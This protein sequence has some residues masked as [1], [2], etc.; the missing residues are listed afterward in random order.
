MS[1]ARRIVRVFI[2]STFRDLH[3]ER[4]HLVKVVFPELRERLDPYRID[5]VDI[6][7][8]WGITEAQAEDGRVLS[9]C[10]E[11]IDACRPFFVG[12]LGQRYG[13][14]PDDL[15]EDAVQRYG[16]V[17]RETGKSITELE[18][19]HGVLNDPEMRGRAFFYFRDPGALETVSEDRRSVY[20]DHDPVLQ[21]RLRQLKERIVASGLP[22]V[23]D[24]PARWDPDAFDRPTRSRGRLGGL[25]VFGETVL[26]DLWEAIRVEQDLPEVPPR[27]ATTSPLQREHAYHERFMDGRLEG[28]T[29]RDDLHQALL[30]YVDGD[31]TRPLLLTGAS[32]SGKSS[33]LAR[34][35]REL[36]AEIR[37]GTRGDL[38]LVPHFTGASPRS[39]GL[40]GLLTRVLD[41]LAL[42]Y[43][44]EYD[45]AAELR[46]LIETFREALEQVPEGRRLLLVID[47]V[48]QFEER[49]GA[50]RLAWLPAT[51]PPNVRVVLSTIHSPA[52][53]SEAAR[54]ATRRDYRLLEVEPLSDEERRA[55]AR[56]VPSIAAKTLDESQLELLLSNPA[57]DNPLF[58]RVALEELRGF[59]SF[60]ALGE[61][62][63]EFP[64]PAEKRDPVEEIFLQVIQRV[65][66]DFDAVLV[67][68]VLRLLASARRGLSEPELRRLIEWLDAA[69][70]LFPVLRQLRPYLMRRGELIAFFHDALGRAALARYLAAEAEREAAHRRLAD[71]FDAQP[72]FL[73]DAAEPRTPNLRRVDELPWQLLRSGGVERLAERLQQ[74]TFVEAKA[75]AGLVD[76]LAEDY[77]AAIA[78]LEETD[79]HR[80]V[81]KVLSRALD[82]EIGFLLRHPECLFQVLWNR[83][84]W[85]DAPESARHFEVPVHAPASYVPPWERTGSKVSALLERLRHE[86]EH[87]PEAAP[88][89]R[90]IVPPADLFSVPKTVLRG[91]GKGVSDLIWSLKG[92]RLAVGSWDGT[93]RVW[94]RPHFGEPIELRGHADIVKQLAWSPDGTRLASASWDGTVRIWML[95]G[96]SELLV[97]HHEGDVRQLAWSS[98]GEFVASSALVLQGEGVPASG[99]VRIWAADQLRELLVLDHDS[100]VVDHLAWSPDGR[101]LAYV[102]GYSTVWVWTAGEPEPRGPLPALR[103]GVV[104]SL[105]WSPGGACLAASSNDGKVRICRADGEGKSLVLHDES[106]TG[107]H[108][109]A[110]VAW[111]PDGQR[112]AGAYHDGIVRIWL[113]RPHADCLELSGHSEEVVHVAWSPDGK[114][115]ASASR[116]YT[117]IVWT[118]DGSQVPLVLQGH[119]SN[120]ERVAWSPDGEYVA[121]AAGESVHLWKPRSP[122]E[123][124]GRRGHGQ[125]VQQF[126]W[127]PTGDHIAS[128]SFDGI[129]QVQRVDE[130]YQALVLSGHPPDARTNLYTTVEHLVW[131]PDG[132][133][134]AS[135]GSG[136]LQLWCVERPYTA[137]L[138]DAPG[139]LFPD[140][141]TYL[142]WSQGG[143]HLAIAERAGSVHIYPGDGNGEPRELLGDGSSIEHVAWSLDGK[144]LAGASLGGSVLVW[145]AEGRGKPLV[146]R[147]HRDEV[148]H[149]AWSPN[150]HRLA[151]ASNDGTVRFWS[152]DEGTGFVVPCGG[153]VVNRVAW[154]PHGDRLAGAC[155]DGTVRVWRAHDGDADRELLVLRGQEEVLPRVA[156]SPSGQRLAC[157]ASDGTVRVWDSASGKILRTMSESW[158]G[159][160]DA[161]L[162]DS[163]PPF[164]CRRTASGSC[165]VRGEDGMPVTHFEAWGS[166]HP[167]GQPIWAAP[168][169]S[170]VLLF[171][172]EGVEA[173]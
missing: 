26:D 135:A 30:A 20:E 99:R 83:G 152:P 62:I 124:L 25:E 114:H 128:A 138:L 95:D 164:L 81:L 51:L 67:R 8:R 107:L 127:S 150:G 121:T 5:L 100:A 137:A 148:G 147:G 154:S 103:G 79:P 158:D 122:G 6:D 87:R 41:T 49:D 171:K 116:D 55:I 115:L 132:R 54:V 162:A 130:T 46:D 108:W 33:I 68:E 85:Y 80:Y 4:D 37:V 168:S 12:L 74:L 172:L 42:T 92:E 53:T 169:G 9:L 157:A 86:R 134:L 63:R 31:E 82:Y 111:S 17:Q 94:Q 142:A 110:H 129:V 139:A 19:L 76:D 119:E 167:R 160:L 16:W 133:R 58:L 89:V 14:V 156:W 165:I 21:E 39:T 136:V 69:D 91:H 24:Y 155:S 118:A 34:L 109:V 101:Q 56:A 77:R 84:W 97:L 145:S 90:R 44:L 10:L 40:R 143:D 32:G 93:I 163:P 57:T 18:I 120:V 173:S 65:A 75:E 153:A 38:L 140:P 159:S 22:V 15:P 29:G 60:E 170:S 96:E 43:E 88:W 73:D 7:L 106:Y 112:L 48:N 66:E 47:A 105:T 11:Q 35:A 27:E 98:S 104:Q 52:G 45:T 50:E 70:D 2:S 61:R 78:G 102:S 59:P 161:V 36:Q 1:D 72:D 166:P 117:A 13:W 151:S 141:I 28:Y 146:L 64:Q 3:A 144:R 71:F 131:S 149:V 126:A 113:L 23:D 125:R 123:P